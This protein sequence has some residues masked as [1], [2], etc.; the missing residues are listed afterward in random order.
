MKIDYGKLGAEFHYSFIKKKIF[1]EEFIGSNL[2]Y[3]CFLQKELLV[4]D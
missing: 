4:V 3:S 2:N 1:A